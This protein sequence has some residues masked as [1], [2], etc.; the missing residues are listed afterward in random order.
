MAGNLRGAF[1]SGSVVDVTG[2]VVND[3]DLGL[4]Q[5]HGVRPWV[6]WKED[7]TIPHAG[8]LVGG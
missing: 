8:L 3:A 2:K 7:H 5:W 6:E 1:I 4:F